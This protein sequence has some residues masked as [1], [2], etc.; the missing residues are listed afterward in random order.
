MNF[1]VSSIQY[2]SS[3]PIKSLDVPNEDGKT[4]RFPESISKNTIEDLAK[5]V[6]LSKD[7]NY[8]EYL[9][10]A[11]EQGFEGLLP[12]AVNNGLIDIDILVSATS[13]EAKNEITNIKLAVTLTAMNIALNDLLGEE[14]S[15]TE[16]SS[17]ADLKYEMA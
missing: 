14:L 2:L 9:R 8:D 16:L 12:I 1:D 3:F 6:I 4:Y 17:K 11:D 15:S 10:L 7:R 13:E 5:L